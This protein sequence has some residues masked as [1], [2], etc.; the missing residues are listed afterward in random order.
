M[1][2]T[3]S[4]DGRVSELNAAKLL[5]LHP[6]SLARLRKEG[7]GPVWYDLALGGARVTYRL[8]DLSVWIESRRKNVTG[9][10][11]NPTEG[12]ANR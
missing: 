8:F 3:I 4:A 5:D 12:D 1:T 6:D 7:K 11:L 10:L 9:K 2:M